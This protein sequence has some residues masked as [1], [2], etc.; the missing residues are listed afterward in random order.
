MKKKKTRHLIP[1]M[2]TTNGI[3]FGVYTSN[4]GYLQIPHADSSRTAYSNPGVWTRWN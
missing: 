1:D 4:D 3:S 2:R